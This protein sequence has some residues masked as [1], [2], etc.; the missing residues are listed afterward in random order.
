MFTLP[1]ST[2]TQ[3]LTRGILATVESFGM[4]HAMPPCLAVDVLSVQ[5]FAR[6]PEIEP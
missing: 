1:R 6:K 4:P 3:L 5:G 2:N